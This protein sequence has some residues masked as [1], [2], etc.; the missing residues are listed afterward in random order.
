MIAI[1]RSIRVAVSL[2]MVCCIGAYGGQTSPAAGKRTRPD[3]PDMAEMRNYRLSMAKVDKFAAASQSLVALSKSNPAMKSAM[4][5]G[6]GAKTM[7][8]GVKLMESKYPEAAAA[9][10]KSG[11]NVREYFLISVTLMTT[12]MVA[13]MKKQGQKMDQLPSTVSPENVAFV[14]QNYPRIEKLLNG[15]SGPNE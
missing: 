14:E 8:E 13:G 15:L 11:L 4:Q 7:D 9:I 12:T 10:Q 3:T 1:I 6:M 5:G 2:L